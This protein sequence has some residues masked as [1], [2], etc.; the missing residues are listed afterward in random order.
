MLSKPRIGA[1]CYYVQ[2][3]SRTEAFYRDV[4]GPEVQ[5]MD[6]DEAGVWLM[7]AIEN[8]VELIFF[9][10]E[11]KPAIRRSSSSISLKAVST[12]WSVVSLKKAP[13]SSRL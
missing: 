8:N 10:T 11:S 9:V 3:I 6:D 5:R 13:R 1:V 4:L 12:T 2:E 7:A